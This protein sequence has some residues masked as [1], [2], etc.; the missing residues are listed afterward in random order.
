MSFVDAIPER[1]RRNDSLKKKLMK[2]GRD[3]FYQSVPARTNN[4]LKNSL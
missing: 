2:P 3:A 1:I 4:N